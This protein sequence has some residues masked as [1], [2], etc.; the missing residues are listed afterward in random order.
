MVQGQRVG[1]RRITRDRYGRTIAELYVN[2][3][4]V[5]QELVNQ[6]HAWIYGR[7]AYQCGWAN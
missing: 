7:Y 4:N 6:G 5:G 3:N 2:G 1:I